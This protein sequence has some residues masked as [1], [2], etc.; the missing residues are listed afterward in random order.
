MSRRQRESLKKL[1]AKALNKNQILILSEIEISDF[2]TITSTL[3]KLSKKSGIPLSTLKM[4]AKILKQMGLIEFDSS[5][6][7]T[8][9][10]ELIIQIIGGE[11]PT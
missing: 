6:C 5:V 4:N 7:L 1:L 2:K 8:D 9:F 11:I 10:G 3:T